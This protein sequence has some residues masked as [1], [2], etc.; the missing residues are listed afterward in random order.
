MHKKPHRPFCPV[1]EAVL[2]MTQLGRVLEVSPQGQNCRG[3]QLPACCFPSSPTTHPHPQ[4]TDS[5]QPRVISGG[6]RST[7]VGLWDKQGPTISK[8]LTGDHS[9]SPQAC[10]CTFA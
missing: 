5:R 8:Q 7:A 1:E 10:L 3:H 9:Y 6:T 2:T 4:S